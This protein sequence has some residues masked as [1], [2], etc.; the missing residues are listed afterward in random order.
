MKKQV[1]LVLSD[2]SNL[3]RQDYAMVIDHVQKRYPE[4][5]VL[6]RLDQTEKD[7]NQQSETVVYDYFLCTIERVQDL[8]VGQGVSVKYYNTVLKKTQTILGFVKIF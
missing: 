6:P 4:H 3:S 1:V 5:L 8:S 2:F 7:F